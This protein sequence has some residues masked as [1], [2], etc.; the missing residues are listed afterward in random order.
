MRSRTLLSLLLLSLISSLAA[1]ADSDLLPAGMLLNCTMDEPGFSSKSA[2]LNDPVLCHV[3][4]TSAFGRSVFPRGTYLTGHLQEYKD[5]GHFYGK[6]W[7]SL[8]FDRL[9]FPGEAV[10]PLAAKVVAVPH[11]KVARD[12][13]IIGSG[14]ARRDAVEWAVPV[15]WPVKVATLPARGPYPTIKGEMRITLRLMDDVAIPAPARTLTEVPMPAWARTSD[16]NSGFWQRVDGAV[17]E[18]LGQE[19]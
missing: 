12:G 4:T 17:R 1:F 11:Y 19:R 16:A 13:R 9:V 6:G 15:L 2:E 3:G 7:L 18:T 14:H 10:L 8:E 5:P